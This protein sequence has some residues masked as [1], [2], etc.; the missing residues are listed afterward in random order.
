VTK[1]TKGDPLKAHVK[2]DE[3]RKNKIE[4][5]GIWLNWAQTLDELLKAKMLTF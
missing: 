5:F 2:V 1:C 3:R 4:Q